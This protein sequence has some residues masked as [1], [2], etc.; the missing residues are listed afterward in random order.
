[1][2]L[3]QSILLE[4]GDRK[5]MKISEFAGLF[6]IPINTVRFYV[7]CGLLLPEVRNKQFRFDARCV[8]DMKLILQL[9]EF[10]FSIAE[11]QSILAL[12]R[13]SNLTAED[14][15][16]DLV[17]I[18]NTK[19]AELTEKLAE[20]QKA[21]RN[22]ERYIATV[23][24]KEIMEEP[25]A[26]SGVPIEML[27]LLCCP[28]C[29]KSFSLQNADIRAGQILEADISCEC[30][31]RAS[32][33]DGI[34]ITEG[35]WI[36]Q[37]DSPDVDR[38]FY[39]DLPVSWVT[40]FQ[41]SFNWMLKEYKEMDLSGKVVLENHINFYFF[42]FARISEMNRN[43]VY[44]FSDKYQ[45]IVALFKN[46]IERQNPDLKILYIADSTYRYPLR[47]ECVDMYV[48][49]CSLNEYSTF[50]DEENLFTLME[51]YL[52]PDAKVLGTYFYFDPKSPSQKELVREY[53]DCA[54]DDYLLPFYIEAARQAGYRLEKEEEIG[55]VTDNGSE[56][57]NFTF[58]VGEDPMHMMSYL[59]QFKKKKQP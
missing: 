2:L 54:K 11:I 16:E 7:S 36:S 34:L 30:G 40:L 18:L 44:I 19:H 28:D 21:I 4:E 33:R 1:M 8:S 22:L 51:P 27:P 14:D 31:Y 48:D 26:V 39:K 58:H 13:L 43:A 12:V 45:E 38:K 3:S 10:D 35:G 32:I 37:Y 23:R 53:P 29:G 46:L 57:R 47:K 42:C 56:N 41:K 9:K 59:A 17:H 5:Q 6:D 50:T 15:I 25:A 20:S 52:K 49:F 55:F 24:R